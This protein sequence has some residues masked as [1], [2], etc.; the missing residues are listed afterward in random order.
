MTT[1]VE[2]KRNNNENAVNLIRR[3]TK[4]VKGSGILLRMRS[5]VYYNRPESKFRKKA[6]ALKSIERRE[7]IEHL[8]K[9]GKMPEKKRG[10]RR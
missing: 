9:L 6:R 1:N 2:V 7:E 4:R 10:G 3:F 5:N 8:K